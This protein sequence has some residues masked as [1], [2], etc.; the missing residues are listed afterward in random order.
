V[1]C[2]HF[3]L[4]HKLISGPF[5]PLFLFSK[6]GS[7]EPFSFLCCPGAGLQFFFFISLKYILNHD[8]F[9]RIVSLDALYTNASYWDGSQKTA[10][11]KMLAIGTV[12]NPAS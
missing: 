2:T 5:K 1:L 7:V 8:F 9:N 12:R 10:H 11:K 3:W 6:G 4:L